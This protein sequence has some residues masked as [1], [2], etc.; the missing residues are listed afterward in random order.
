MENKVLLVLIDGLR[1]DAVMQCKHQFLHQFMTQSCTYSFHGRSVMPSITLP[2]HMSLFHSVTPDRHGVMDNLYLRPSHHIDGLC[3]VLHQ[4]KKECA[5]FYT[6]AELRDLCRP[7][8]LARE[9]FSNYYTY[10]DKA[11]REMCDRAIRSLRTE[12]PD[13]IFY[14]TGNT[15]E[16]AHKYGWMSPEYMD[17]VALASEHVEK[18]VNALPPEYAMAI[19]A[20]HGGHA[21][22]HGLDIP[23]DMTI[24]ISLY[25]PQWEKGKELASIRLIDLA[26]TIAAMLDCEIPA[27]WDGVSLL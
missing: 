25:G 15:D 27:D 18:L 1:P 19:T 5:F 26:P 12:K 7:G 9:E 17:A 14:Y 8:S 2:C 3:E 11:D 20:D 16:V 4:K 10:G 24:P 21:R 23:E 13:F 6:W 22:N